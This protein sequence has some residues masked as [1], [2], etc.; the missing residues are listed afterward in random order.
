MTEINAASVPVTTFAPKRHRRISHN[1]NSKMQLNKETSLATE[2][3]FE[4]AAAHDDRNLRTPTGA[5]RQ[6]VTK[7]A[8]EPNAAISPTLKLYFEKIDAEELLIE[9]AGSDD[10]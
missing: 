2:L 5:S 1:L 8:I 7:E 3:R 6:A 10:E 9:E 4:D